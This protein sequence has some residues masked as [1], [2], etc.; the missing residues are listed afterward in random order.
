MSALIQLTISGKFKMR[1][2]IHIKVSCL[3]PHEFK[4]YKKQ[5][6]FPA[7]NAMFKAQPRLETLMKP[8]GPTNPPTTPMR[9]LDEARPTVQCTIH[10]Q[11]PTTTM[12]MQSQPVLRNF[13][14]HYG[15]TVRPPNRLIKEM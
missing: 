10:T 12:C 1:N 11:F 8:H 9:P 4:E 2:R 6:N 15:N 14:T 7:F 5:N 3:T 13:V